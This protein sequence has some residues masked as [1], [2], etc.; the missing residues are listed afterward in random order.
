MDEIENSYHILWFYISCIHIWLVCSHVMLVRLPTCKWLMIGRNL[1]LILRHLHLH[2]FHVFQFVF[3]S[4]NILL[5][6]KR[7]ICFRHF[8]WENW[9][10]NSRETANRK[11]WVMQCLV[12]DL[13]YILHAF[14]HSYFIFNF[15][16]LLN[17]LFLC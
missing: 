6:N 16:Y 9:E 10:T 8:L 11:Q 3:L 7:W 12:Y 14:I 15:S 17:I 4:G 2:A 13:F 1:H 5:F